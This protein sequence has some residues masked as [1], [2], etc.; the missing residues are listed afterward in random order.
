MASQPHAAHHHPRKRL[1]VLALHSFRTSGAIFAEQQRRA[2]LDAALADLI[3][4]VRRGGAG[5][6]VTSVPCFPHATPPHA[7]Q[8]RS[9]QR[10]PPNTRPSA[11]VLNATAVLLWLPPLVQT[12]I[13][14]P[15]AASGPIPD[16]VAPH[17]EGPYYEWWVAG[18]CACYIPSRRGSGEELITCFR[19]FAGLCR[20]PPTHLPTHLPR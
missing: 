12:Y 15:N 20:H 17:F 11:A 5:A 19:P 4:V 10:Q 2:G 3:D 16:D 13:D 6:L 1:R 9:V 8:C 14:A 18:R 7:T